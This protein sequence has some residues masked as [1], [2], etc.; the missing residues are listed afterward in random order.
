[1]NVSRADIYRLTEPLTASL[2]LSE[3]EFASRSTLISSVKITEENF[4]SGQ[5]KF[6]DILQFSGQNARLRYAIRLVN[7][8]G[9]KAAFSNFLLIEPTAKVAA[10]PTDL[11]ATISEEEILLTWKVPAENVDGSKPANILGFNIY[12]TNIA[13][14]LHGTLNNTPIT[15]NKFGDR[16]FEF[17]MNYQ[18]F[19][20]TISLGANGEP[21]E[22]LNSNTIEVKP[23]DIF[24]PSPPSAIT[25]AAAPG[26][27][28]IFFAVNPEN[29]IAGY[30]IYRTTDRNQS[31]S[32]WSLLTDQLLT[33]NTFQDKNVQSGKT[34]FYYLTAI[35]KSGN[36]SEASII[37]SETAP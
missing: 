9:Q 19:V 13:E 25:I 2:T 15:D 1:L 8:S 12:R 27:L 10:G 6:E 33:T 35:D 36:S 18:Y 37:V 22:S 31:L 28:S 24:P 29:D 20:R 17:G 14:E 4:R 5:V 26:N 16:S 32:N 34:Y 21:V 7:A 30:R 11:T 23:R 3:E